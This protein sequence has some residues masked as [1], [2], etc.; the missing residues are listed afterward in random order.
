MA[1]LAR[2]AVEQRRR[3]Q[4][5]ELVP[6]EAFLAQQPELQEDGDA[7][8][9]LLFREVALR[10]ERGDEPTLGE[11]LQRFPQYE[12]RVRIQFDLHQ[13]Q[14]PG[15]AEAAGAAAERVLTPTRD[16]A[17]QGATVGVQGS[18]NRKVETASAP[19][20]YP[21]I[22]G[23]EILGELGR[24]GMGVVYK[25]RQTRLDRLVALKM[26]LSGA[27]AA[28]DELERFRTEAKAVARL[29]HPN[30]VQ[31]YEVGEHQGR[32]YFSLEF[33]DGGSLEPQIDGKP[34]PPSEAARLVETLARA[35]HYAHQRGVIHRDLK[36]ANILLHKD[37]GRRMKDEQGYCASFI[38]KITDFGLAKRM[39]APD[40]QTRT[41]E[42]L[43]TPSYMAPEQAEGRVRDV[44]C[45][46]DIYALGAILYE[47]LTGRP[48]FVA[49]MVWDVIRQVIADE[50][51]PP[52]RLQAQVPRDLET[53]CL[54]CLEKSP[55]RRY[56]SAEA[57][58]EDLHRFL[59]GEHI[60]AR[61]V[62]T[63]Q[64]SVKW[65]RRHPAVTALLTVGTL[66][67]ATL[68][69][70]GWAYNIQLQRALQE[71]HEKREESRQRLG[72][73]VVSNG[74]R[75]LD[76]G[77]WF[78]ALL[79][80][81]EALRLDQGNAERE[82]THRL[83]LAA[84]LQQCPRLAQLWFH[85]AAVR[86]VC[87]SPD[88][89][90]LAT[91]G[92]DGMARV[93]D[94]NTGEAITPPLRH[95]GPVPHVVFSADG[96]FLA[97]AGG[98]GTA[99][100]WDL[101]TGKPRTGPLR[102]TQAVACVALNHDGSRLAAASDDG[103][104]H[105]WDTATGQALPFR[106]DH[107]GPVCWVAF[108]CDG[109]LVVT[110]SN[111]HT[112]RIW[113]AASGRA[114]TS[115]LIHG[116]AVVHVCFSPDGR[117]VLT[118]SEDRTARL[119]DAA[120]GR[121]RG[122][123]LRHV[124]AIMHG[125]FSADGQRVAT[126]SD[127]RTARVWNATSGAP[128]S[129]PMVHGSAVN[130]AHFSPDGQWLVTASDDNGAHLW[131][132]TTG[133]AVPPKVLHHGTLRC[134]AFC[135]DGCQ[136]LTASNDTTVRLLHLPPEHL[137]TTPPRGD[138][139]RPNVAGASTGTS[140]E[141][142]VIKIHADR[143]ARVH[144]AATGEPLSPPLRH[145]SYVLQAAFSPDGRRVVTASDDD[146]ARV[147]D[148]AT[149]ELVGPP[150]KHSGSVLHAEFSPDGRLVVTGSMDETARVWN[151]ATGEAI[152]PPLRH[153]CEV[154]HATFSADGGQVIT[155]GTDG[156]ARTWPLRVEERSVDELMALAQVLA[157]SRIDPCRG[158]LPL[159][160]TRLRELWRD[161]RQGRH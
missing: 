28:K 21:A 101:R 12:S 120:T 152:T 114:V 161:V 70:G 82:H 149:G 78:G 2:L 139:Y 71:A 17:S 141:G 122:V 31:I 134:V 104:A 130:H 41:G 136:L 50:P 40:G 46:T 59:V 11:L 10:Q 131:N 112:A 100:V 124:R 105:L 146:T 32:P 115:P 135:P 65:A 18:S 29:H 128:I 27:H 3:W 117:C 84:V 85:E 22:P 98:D 51:L 91:A 102:H 159:E 142:R 154:R 63:I 123:P 93:W 145:S 119:W 43:G 125:S 64:R 99:R 34:L 39:D 111:D 148:V 54:K 76:H 53:I 75:L 37:E 45:H 144:N 96:R 19:G 69:V 129:P 110:A 15:A 23:H 151:A 7:I 48:P 158:F 88:G 66:A 5:G 127:D 8:V 160:M 26:I 109:R 25:A 103:A 68:T 133:T 72:R 138:K 86:Y 6:V 44:G 137:R 94:A 67:L 121:A 9:D 156:V 49:E 143:S 60:Q 97:T 73:L 140:R 81:T 118:S 77:D 153:C 16:T 33:V 56:A 14:W 38:A 62:S 20:N 89:R 126:A 24:G 95:D 74:T 108:S 113:D 80:F 79:W 52:T 30:L 147:W 150:L 13:A 61:P 4:G 42:V 155:T 35:M 57:L 1:L 87:F 83:R 36:P 90:R 58:A 106:L 47:L 92:D 107:G 132:A 55:S 116:A 157:G